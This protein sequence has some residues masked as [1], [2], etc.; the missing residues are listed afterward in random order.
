MIRA[1]IGPGGRPLDIQFGMLHDEIAIGTAIGLA[2]GLLLLALRVEDR[3]AVR[4]MLVLVGLM[5]ALDLI[6]AALDLGG[7]ARGARLLSG[8]AIVGI[9][10]VVI[11]LGGLLVFRV[12]LPKLRFTSA[13]IVEDLTVTVLAAAWLLFWLH[14]AGLDLGSLVATSAVITAVLAFSMQDTLGNILG[15]VVLQLDDSVRVGDWVKV[16][17]VSGQV[18]DVRWRHTAIETR[19]RETVIIPNGWL[20]K[21]RFHILGSRREARTR[22]RRWVWFNIE[23]A[24]QPGR[25]CQVLEDSVRLAEIANVAQDPPP[26]AVLMDVGQ[27]YARYALRYWLTDPRPDDPSDSAVRMHALAALARNGMRLA[28]I[29]EER[30]IT[31]ENQDR[32]DRL[33]ADELARRARALAAVDLFSAFS[34]AEREALAANMVSAPFVQGDTITRQG[35]VAHWLYLVAEGEVDVWSE[36]NGQRTHVATLDAGSTFGEMGMMTGEPRRATVT[37]RSDVLCLRLDKAGFESVLR[38][39]P[40][41]AEEISRVIA[42]RA[43][44]LSSIRDAAASGPAAAAPDAISA[45]IRRFFGLD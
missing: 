3:P 17:G 28:V 26:S 39:R 43:G 7:A 32:Q 22:W 36:A 5:V 45:R 24:A 38:A 19:D 15:G 40:D 18:V 9:G 12:I 11:R 8:I 31:K 10:A 2:L 6:A 37:A 44:G 23:I 42:E 4:G 29:Q 14:G 1:S 34:D 27:G 25:V 20:V 30:L 33:R 13:R 21:N 16:D 41:I 35:A